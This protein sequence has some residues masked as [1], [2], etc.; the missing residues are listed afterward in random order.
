VDQPVAGR[1]RRVRRR[2]LWIVLAIVLVLFSAV[3]ARVFIWPDLPPLPQRA[4]AIIELGGA[5]NPEDR[6]AAALALAR[7]HRAPVLVQST[8]A[9]EAGT[10]RC[11]PAVPDVTIMCFHPEPNTTR[12]EARA[13][14]ALAARHRWTSVILVT[15]P[16]HAWRARLRVSRCFPGQVYVSTVRLPTMEWFGQI[17]YQWSASAKALTFERGC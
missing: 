3:T 16:D 9:V 17:P 7:D 10:D 1:A 12:G 13:I 2:R 8:V 5:G 15:T 6:D 11:L 14:A 4:D